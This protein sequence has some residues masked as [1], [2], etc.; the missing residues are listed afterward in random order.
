[1]KSADHPKEGPSLAVELGAL[2]L[3]N[4]VIAASGTFGYGEE[5]AS[6]IP[7]RSL[8]GIVTKGLSLEPR[9][10][11]PPPRLAETPSGMLNAIGLENVG[12]EKFILEKWPFLRKASCPVIVNIFGN[13]IEEY[14]ELARR[15]ADVEGIAGLEVNISC[16]N[17]KA[18]G[19]I[20]ASEPRTVHKVVAKIRRA[21]SSF[22][23]VKLSPNVSDISE[24]A[25][26]AEAG[27]ADAVSLINTLI[28]MA[29]DL[30][31]RTPLLGNI[32]GGLSGPAIKPVGLRMV[33]QVA[34]TVHIPIVGM[35]GIVTAE[36]ALEYLIAGATAVQVGSAHFI[37]PRAGLKIIDGI[38]RYLQANNFPDVASLV[39]SLKIKK[40]TGQPT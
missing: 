34:Q 29:I 20:F 33:W 39:G 3:R 10:G 8:G 16:P 26:A 11:N 38:Q 40:D 17:L 14:A 28:G 4:P 21:T 6:L 7:L 25:Q 24:I 27:G 36:D 19:A 1:M 9:R 2:K 15:L 18:G 35:G 13:T 37:D 32:T 12:L 30:K 5:Y 23:M 22:L 31:K